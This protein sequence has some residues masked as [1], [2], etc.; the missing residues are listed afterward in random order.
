M[1]YLIRSQNK[2][3]AYAIRYD[4]Q[5]LITFNAWWRSNR[6]NSGTINKVVLLNG[7]VTSKGQVNKAAYDPD[8]HP[9]S[10][11]WSGGYFPELNAIYTDS[12]QLRS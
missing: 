2:P 4:A 3:R 6:G 12:I 8:G 7:P 10:A 1:T 5:R 9:A 11:R